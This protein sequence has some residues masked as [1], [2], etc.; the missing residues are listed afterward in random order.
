MRWCR[1]LIAFGLLTPPQRF[2]D[3]LFPPFAP[4]SLAHPLLVGESGLICITLFYPRLKRRGQFCKHAWTCIG[5]NNIFNE[6]VINFVVFYVIIQNKSSN[7]H[8]FD[9]N[10]VRF[11]KSQKVAGCQIGTVWRP[12][13]FAS[14]TITIHN[15]QRYTWYVDD[16]VGL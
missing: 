12:D 9:K 10:I 6:V 5:H 16:N 3:W 7:C 15:N 4:P 11:A 1:E 13:D 14:D 2:K 8:L